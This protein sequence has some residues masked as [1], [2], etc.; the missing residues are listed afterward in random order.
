MSTRILEISSYGRYSPTDRDIFMYAVADR[1]N[2][3]RKIEIENCVSFCFVGIRGN[4][5]FVRSQTLH[6]T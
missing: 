3:P 5:I 6:Y 4:N 2:V 1:R